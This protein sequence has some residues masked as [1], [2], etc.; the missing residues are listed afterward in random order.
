LGR[1]R[2]GTTRRLRIPTLDWQHRNR[3]AFLDSVFVEFC[4]LLLYTKRNTAAHICHDLNT[5][6]LQMVTYHVARNDRQI[7]VF[8][9]LVVEGLDWTLNSSVVL[10]AVLG[11]FKW[12]PFLDL[13]DFYIKA[14]GKVIPHCQH[15]QSQW[16]SNGVHIHVDWQKRQCVMNR[17]SNLLVPFAFLSSCVTDEV[18]V[19]VEVNLWPTV[20]RPSGTRDQFFYLLEI[21]FRQLRV[22][23]LVAHS[24]TRGRVCNLLYNC[25]WALPEQLFLSWSPAELTTIF[26]CLIWDSPNLEDLVPVFISPRN[27]VAQLYPRGT[28]FP[29]SRL[30]R[31]AGQRW[32]YSNPPPHGVNYVTVLAVF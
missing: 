28:E 20:R 22:C 13:C 2:R 16:S 1:N 8:H 25:F 32:R 18:E 9:Y 17:F 21:F 31:L 10:E 27:R 5:I 14:P 11:G 3:N 15:V 7:T 24:L 26:Y 29:L 12:T 30:L 4:F 23:Y 6:S 19:E